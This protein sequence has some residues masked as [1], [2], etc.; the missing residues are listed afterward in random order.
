MSLKTR[1]SLI[2]SG[3]WSEVKVKLL[4]KSKVFYDP[5]HGSRNFQRGG[6]GGGKILKEKCLLIHVSTRIHIKIRQSCN[7]FPFLHFQEDCLLFFALFYYS[8][9]FLK[10]ERGGCN[11]VTPPLDPPMDPLLLITKLATLVDKSSLI[12]HSDSHCHHIC[13]TTNIIILHCILFETCFNFATGGHLCFL[14]N[15]C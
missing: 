10:F 2:N 7:S 8:L 11:P 9:L 13:L 12:L 3:Y 1:C 15:F 6:G 5:R 4:S 14:K